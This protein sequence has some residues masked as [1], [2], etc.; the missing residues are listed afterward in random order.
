LTPTSTACL[1]ASGRKVPQL[2]NV[3]N[4]YLRPKSRG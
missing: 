3:P 4:R 1:E 2:G